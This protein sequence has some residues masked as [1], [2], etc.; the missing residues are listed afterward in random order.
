VNEAP[1]PIHQ[2]Q[3]LVNIR[4]NSLD[5]HPRRDPEADDMTELTSR[6]DDDLVREAFWVVDKPEVI[7]DEDEDDED[8]IVY[9]RSVYSLRLTHARN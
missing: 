6:T 9:M 3:L 7:A 1:L 8:E 5:L 2:Q 4:D